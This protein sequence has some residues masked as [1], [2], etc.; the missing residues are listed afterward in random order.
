MELR[1]KHPGHFFAQQDHRRVGGL[2]YQCWQSGERQ[3]SGHH[4]TGREDRRVGYLN[5]NAVSNP[6]TSG[7]ADIL[8]SYTNPDK[9]QTSYFIYD[10]V[11]EYSPQLKNLRG[12]VLTGK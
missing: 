10:T 6:I 12:L 8:M 5:G 3:S 2:Q 1:K 4:W 11:N 9:N 7:Q